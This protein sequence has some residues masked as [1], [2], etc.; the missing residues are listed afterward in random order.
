LGKDAPLLQGRKLFGEMPS[1]GGIVDKP[2]RLSDQIELIKETAFKQG[3]DA[4][5]DSGSMA[6]QAEGRKAGFQR[7]MADVNAARVEEVAQFTRDLENFRLEFEAAA[8]DWMAR[9]EDRNR[10]FYGSC[11]ENPRVRT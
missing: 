4:G 9:T 8:A 6:G 2:Q 5:F 7:A 11:S 10:P 3:Y 1:L